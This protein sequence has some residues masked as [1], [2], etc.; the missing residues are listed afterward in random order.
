[1]GQTNSTLAH[2]PPP[3][4]PPPPPPSSSSSSSPKMPSLE[5]LRDI[6]QR[7]LAT[8][9]KALGDIGGTLV[10]IAKPVVSSLPGRKG[11]S[12]PAPLLPPPPP[13]SFSSQALLWTRRNA[14]RIALGTVLLGVAVVVGS[15]ANKA[16]R[17]YRRQKSKLRVVRAADGSR[18]EIIVVTNVATIEGE[19]LALS[20]E[21]R[22][23]I[24][25]V[26]VPNE[27]AAEETHGWGRPDIH[28]VIV[29]D[30]SDFEALA[31]AVSGFLE[32]QNYALQEA[33]LS[34]AEA[35]SESSSSS[36]MLVGNEHLPPP[37]VN[38]TKI[39]RADGQDTMNVSNLSISPLFR[40]SAVV[41]NPQEAVVGS[42]DTV[43]VLAWRRCLDINVTGTI[44]T[45]QLFLSLFKSNPTL[46]APRRS[47]RLI[48]IT[49]V[50]TGTIGLPRQSALCASHHAI[51]SIADSLRR[52]VQH[53]G[54][55][56]V[57]L[58][59]GIMESSR[60]LK[61]KP[62]AANVG[63]LEV[64]SWSANPVELLKSTFRQP[65]TSQALCDATFDALMA[66]KPAL[67]QLIGHASYVYSFVGWAV[68]N[69]VIDK[70]IQHVSSTKAI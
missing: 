66:P 62:V 48:F 6:P 15:M 28:P 16:R 56:V 13:P 11:S 49:S 61:P 23:F 40:L 19:A 39:E 46:P 4:P 67:S 21:E 44:L 3:P 43:S 58:R 65:S 26:G 7:I 35:A 14:G 55:D 32:K 30:Y 20:L 31:D 5:D 42:I 47:P 64:W 70:S 8:T 18:R 51:T 27:S 36:F 59:A 10:S 9:N 50:I 1:M 45:T 24:V 25:F 22:G 2:S 54:I 38:D 34:E 57:C 41:I 53:K 29:T 17:N 60:Q 37:L 33:S 12:P 52:E 69:R 68:P 63:A